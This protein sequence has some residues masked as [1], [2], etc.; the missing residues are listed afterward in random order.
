MYTPVN[1]IISIITFYKSKRSP[2]S[3]ILALI[4]SLSDVYIFFLSDHLM[5]DIQ[6]MSSAI[7]LSI[8]HLT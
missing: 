3:T 5:D 2:Y 8:M 4:T 6:V 7:T 1:P